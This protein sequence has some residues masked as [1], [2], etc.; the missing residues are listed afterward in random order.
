[1]LRSG[2]CQTR[3]SRTVQNDNAP[4]F[5]RRCVVV[6]AHCRR[7]LRRSARR[8]HTPRLATGKRSSARRPRR[9]YGSHCR[10][11]EPVGVW[12]ANLHGPHRCRLPRSWSR[13]CL[14]HCRFGSARL[15][16]HQRVPERQE[17]AYRVGAALL[18]GA[19]RIVDDDYAVRLP[20]SHAGSILRVGS[21]IDYTLDRTFVPTGAIDHRSPPFKS[22]GG[23]GGRLDH[24]KGGCSL[25]QPS[26]ALRAAVASRAARAQRRLVSDG[27]MTG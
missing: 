8:S 14:D 27:G 6:S 11:A 19:H 22:C 3:S 26:L 20:R 25:V 5:N 17:S 12:L 24:P 7:A 1:M 15:P 4:A 9:R 10:Q 13:F 18:T 23:M 16:D 2:V 21:K